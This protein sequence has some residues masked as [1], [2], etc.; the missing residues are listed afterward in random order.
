MFTTHQSTH[1]IM[2]ES[3]ALIPHKATKERHWDEAEE[4]DEEDCSTY[5]S[6]GLWTAK[7]VKKKEKQ[8]GDYGCKRA[9]FDFQTSHFT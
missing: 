6:L 4:D 9:T 2:W 7:R 1:L 3:H 5:D 8:K